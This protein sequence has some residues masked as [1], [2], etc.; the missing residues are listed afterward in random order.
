MH[1]LWRRVPSSIVRRR[2]RTSAQYGDDLRSASAA[3]SDW[4][5]LLRLLETEP[6]TYRLADFLKWQRDGSLDISPPFQRRSVW[7]AASKGLL[8]DTV[9]RGLPVPLLFLRETIDLDT[10]EIVR[11]VVDGQQRLRTLF[12]YIN[13]DILADYDA[14]RDFFAV[15]RSHNEE[16]A[17]KRFSDLAGEVQHRILSYKFAVV[18]IPTGVEDRDILE[19]FA[20][21]NSTGTKLNHQELRNAEY[22]GEFKSSMYSLALEQLERW[23]SWRVLTDDQIARMLEVQLVSDLAMNAIYGLTG[24]SQK[25]LNDTYKEFDDEMPFKEE[26]ERRLQDTFEDIDNL[27]GPDLPSTVYSSEVHF[28]SLFSYVYDYRWGLGSHLDQSKA[29]RKVPRGLRDC[30]LEVSDRF[31]REDV[32]K[33]VLDAVQRASTD[34]TRRQRRLDFMHEICGA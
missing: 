20:R 11:Q 32:P 16:I 25:R 21:I 33:E 19:I 27:L 5:A 7:N 13:A 2:W 15:R 12:T 30:L 6:T 9:V 1:G 31:R 18:V 22:S 8:I 24:R 14:D 17:G 34:T 23:R 28:F 10:Q 26:L 3:P 4:S 29:G